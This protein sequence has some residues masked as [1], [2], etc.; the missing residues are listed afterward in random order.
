MSG[1][2]LLLD[3]NIIL[4]LLNGDETIADLLDGKE[5]YISVITEME[6]LSFSE[7][8][9]EEVKDVKNFIKE[10]KVVFINSEIKDDAVFLRRKYKT[11]LP[12]AIII[13][14]ALHLNLPLVTADNDF[15]KIDGIRLIYYQK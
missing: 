6:L 9:K 14:T 7:I 13:A 10:C 3:T 12:D 1:N 8:S 11:K 2:K 4:Y 5:I 15:K